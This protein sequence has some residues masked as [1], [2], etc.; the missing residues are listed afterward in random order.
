METSTTTCLLDAHSSYKSV[1]F[2]HSSFFAQLL[3]RHGI[4]FLS[5]SLICTSCILRCYHR[6]AALAQA[7]FLSI[8]IFAL[9]ALLEWLFT[10]LNCIV[11]VFV[12][13]AHC[14]HQSI[15]RA[16]K[17]TLKKTLNWFKTPKFSFKA[18]ALYLFPFILTKENIIKS[19]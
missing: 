15:A 17:C 12:Q 4:P 18:F 2:M 8:A 10:Q 14:T 19:N 9:K 16:I 13:V 6:E 11:L 3:F 5:R 1:H 7:S